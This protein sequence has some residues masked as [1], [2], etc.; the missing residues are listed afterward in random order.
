M[1]V[2][3][4]KMVWK[5]EVNLGVILQALSIL[6]FL[7]RLSHWPQVRHVGLAGWPESPRYLPVSASRFTC[8]F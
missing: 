7:G 8:G 3:T 5:S 6:D 4:L 2:H 1:Y